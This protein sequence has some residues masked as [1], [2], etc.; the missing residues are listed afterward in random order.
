MKKVY[1]LEGLDCA[2]CAAKLERAIGEIEGVSAASISFMTQR[3]TIET[4]EDQLAGV[5]KMVKKTIRKVEPDC[6][7]VE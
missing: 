7:L 3:M 4:Q 2:N 6:T 1:Q 5:M